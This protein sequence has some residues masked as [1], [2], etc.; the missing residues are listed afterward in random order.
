[1]ETLECS[2]PSFAVALFSAAILAPPAAQ[3]IPR[4]ARVTSAVNT[5]PRFMVANPFVYAAADSAAAVKI[6]TAMR[7]E[8]KGTVGRTFR[9]SSRYR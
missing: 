9:S 5:A 7:E 3:G 1:M 8:M 4:G 6:G 2:V